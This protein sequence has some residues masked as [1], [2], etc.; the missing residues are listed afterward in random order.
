MVYAVDPLTDGRWDALV[1]SHPHATVFHTRGW[2][3]ALARTF[4]YE[5]FVLTTTRQGPLANGLL[6]CRVRTVVARRDVSLPFSD[7]CEPLVTDLAT[8]DELVSALREPLPGR[9]VRSIEVRPRSGVSMPGLAVGSRYCLHVLDLARPLPS[10]FAGF[11]SS[12]TRRAVRRAEREGL[13]YESGQSE[14]LLSRFFTLFRLTR[15]RHAAPPQPIAWFRNLMASLPDAARLHVAS[16]SGNPVAAMLTLTRGRTMVYK[17]GGSD[18]SQHRLGGM[19]FLFWRVIEAAHADGIQELDLGR[20]DLSQPGLIAFKD[21]LGAA[22]STLTYS[23]APAAA[24]SA[25]ASPL[26]VAARRALTRLP[27]ALFDLSGRMAYRHLG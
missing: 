4:G 3:T 13:D 22:R 10:I 20:S 2:L 8:L 6:A 27:D 21:H 24:A 14:H 16:K 1:A 17:Y 26:A 23:R 7:H 18:A 5:P 11:D 15:R 19:P 9:R 12:N 25:N